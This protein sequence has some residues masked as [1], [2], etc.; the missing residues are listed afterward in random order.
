M[1]SKF[2]GGNVKY[3][4]IYIYIFFQSKLQFFGMGE[5]RDVLF[6]DDLEGRFPQQVIS[7]CMLLRLDGTLDEV[8]SVVE[9]LYDN[10]ATREELCERRTHAWELYLVLLARMVDIPLWVE[11]Q[12]AFRACLL[13]FI[14][15][16]ALERQCPRLLATWHKRGSGGYADDRS[17]H[18]GNLW[19]CNFLDPDY[20]IYDDDE[21]CPHRNHI[22]SLQI[23]YHGF[24]DV[25]RE[26]LRGGRLMMGFPLDAREKRGQR[27]WRAEFPIVRKRLSHRIAHEEMQ[28]HRLRINIPG[29][30]VSEKRG[31]GKKPD[32]APKK[33]RLKNPFVPVFKLRNIPQSKRNMWS[34]PFQCTTCGKRFSYS[35]HLKAHQNSCL[36]DQIQ[37]K[38]FKCSKCN[39][40]F[41][42][43]GHLTVHLRIHLSIKP[44]RC[45]ICGLSTTQKTNL[46]T[47]YRTHTR[48]IQF[49]CQCCTFCSF[50]KSNLKRHTKTKHRNNNIDHVKCNDRV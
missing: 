49:Q 11:H 4:Y 24:D 43:K 21:K 12:M 1:T 48:R 35:W 41:S 39:V 9:S 22:I 20:N 40:S 33:V 29:K 16:I 42:M 7:G 15:R 26:V 47:H 32:V 46:T 27:R 5:E 38:P 18:L 44:Y 17:L 2:F 28:V 36:P 31:G 10:D 23:P 8:V 30:N 34:H 13:V 6:L 37:Q 3:I 25:N 14:T 19:S 45:N 50:W